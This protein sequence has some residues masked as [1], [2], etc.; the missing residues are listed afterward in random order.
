MTY[1][2]KRCEECDA[3]TDNEP[4]EAYVDAEHCLDP[5]VL[6]RYR[7]C[8]DCDDDNEDTPYPKGDT[9]LKDPTYDKSTGHNHYTLYGRTYYRNGALRQRTV[10]LFFGPLQPVTRITKTT[11]A[12][13]PTGKRKVYA[14][15]ILMS[16][17]NDAGRG[18][19]KVNY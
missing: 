10:T 3:A 15:T 12:P 18:P 7:L 16:L 11:T 2:K 5:P 17:N 14:P 4:Y 9:M 1:C 8:N 6:M 13:L 19:M